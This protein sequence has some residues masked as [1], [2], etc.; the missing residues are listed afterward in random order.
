MIDPNA[1]AAQLRA[2][3]AELRHAGSNYPGDTLEEDTAKTLDAAVALLE[4]SPM[5]AYVG[6]LQAAERAAREA[7]VIAE[8]ERDAARAE[9]REDLLV[10]IDRGLQL[11]TVLDDALEQRTTTTS[12]ERAYRNGYKAGMSAAFGE[13]RRIAGRLAPDYHRKAI[14]K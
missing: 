5:L 8:R 3:A 14:A 11:V 1:L 13:F 4:T 7:L 2:A 10:T 9:T 6:Q 12:R